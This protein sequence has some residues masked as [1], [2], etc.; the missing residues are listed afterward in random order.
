MHSYLQPEIGV[1]LRFKKAENRKQRRRRMAGQ[2]L[3]GVK[4]TRLSM[5]LCAVL[6]TLS[7]LSF[8]QDLNQSPPHSQPHRSKVVSS[9]SVLGKINPDGNDYGARMQSVRDAAVANTVDDLY[10]WSN[11][12]TLLL[13]TGSVSVILLQW[14][15]EAKR[16]VITAAIIAE[17]WNGRVS[18][19][20]ELTRRT[21]Q[22]NQLVETHNAEVEKALAVKQQQAGSDKQ[23]TGNLNRSV[24]KLTENDPATAQRPVPPEPPM[25]EVASIATPD[26]TTANVQQSNLLLRRRVEAMQNTEQNLKQRLN[27]MTALLDQERRR[28]A[29]LKGA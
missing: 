3:R 6:L 4:M 21:E 25:V 13:L 12:M 18:D 14:R 17:L 23:T 29:A 27:Q 26:S 15:S 10:F 19:G 2:C 5:T 11:V 9:T 7:P 16:E 20:I 22:F 24:R 28:N 8:G 1:N